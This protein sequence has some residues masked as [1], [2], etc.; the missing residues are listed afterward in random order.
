MVLF[1]INSMNLLHFNL[2][3]FLPSDPACT[4]M[5]VKSELGHVTVYSGVYQHA[6]ISEG[7]ELFSFRQIFKWKA[8]FL[9]GF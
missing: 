9:K 2:K 3:L 8:K 6:S 5:Q 1:L 4:G 7:N